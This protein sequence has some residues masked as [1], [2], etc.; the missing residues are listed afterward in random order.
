MVGKQL[1][2]DSATAGVQQGNFI[3]NA[4]RIQAAVAGCRQL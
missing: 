1:G 4:E 2:T 3:R